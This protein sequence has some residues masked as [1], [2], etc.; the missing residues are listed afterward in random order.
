MAR[1]GYIKYSGFEDLDAGS[2][3]PEFFY[4]FD[5]F[6]E[7]GSRSDLKINSWDDVDDQQVFSK[8]LLEDRKFKIRDLA[9]DFCT[10]HAMELFEAI[11]DDKFGRQATRDSISELCSV[12]YQLTKKQLENM[13]VDITNLWYFDDATNVELLYKMHVYAVATEDERHQL[14]EDAKSA[15]YKFVYDDANAETA[16]NQDF[17]IKLQCYQPQDLLNWALGGVV[18]NMIRRINY[19]EI[20]CAKDMF[21]MLSG[22]EVLFG[23]PPTVTLK[24]HQ[25]RRPLAIKLLEALAKAFGKVWFQESLTQYAAKLSAGP[26]DPQAN[27]LKIAQ[28]YQYLKGIFAPED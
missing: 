18:K 9:L 20:P 19:H 6:F 17:F 4:E 25:T 2:G 7:S 28:Y 27:M 15:L 11:E 26:D 14:R 12:R 3:V 5:K 21:Q 16:A 8:M 1:Y 24:R 22:G 13:K 23:F 10:D